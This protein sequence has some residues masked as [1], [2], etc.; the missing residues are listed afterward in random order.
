MPGVRRIRKPITQAQLIPPGLNARVQYMVTGGG[1]SDFWMDRKPYLD[2]TTVPADMPILMSYFAFKLGGVLQLEDTFPLIDDSDI[3]ASMPDDSVAMAALR[4]TG[5]PA[6]FDEDDIDNLSELKIFEVEA[7]FG[8]VARGWHCNIATFDSYEDR[9][10]NIT[11]V[12][13][14]IIIADVVPAQI[15]VLNAADRHTMGRRIGLG[16]EASE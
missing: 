11:G 10:T 9:E 13:E 14:E 4:I 8:S 12:R 6:V 16:D 7:R 5:D 1:G 3:F 2:F 15:D